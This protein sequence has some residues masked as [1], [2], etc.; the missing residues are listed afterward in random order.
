MGV[1]WQLHGW[2][3]RSD[4]SAYTGAEH[5]GPASDR[6]AH[7]GMFWGAGAPRKVSSSGLASMATSSSLPSQGA[8]P[9]GSGACDAAL[10]WLPTSLP[11]TGLDVNQQRAS[12]FDHRR[13]V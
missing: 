3:Q 11:G 8:A 6:P 10:K 2:A 1:Y 4:D 13:A 9:A 12:N 5:G 7:E